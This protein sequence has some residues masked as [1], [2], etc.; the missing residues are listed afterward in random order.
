MKNDIDL[1]DFW[2]ILWNGKF[3][4]ISLTFIFLC[5]GIFTNYYYK[6]IISYK[7]SITIHELPSS[8]LITL[9]KI[10]DAI[11]SIVDHHHLVFDEIDQRFL[12]SNLSNYMD[13][14]ID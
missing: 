6:P 13:N 7:S 1:I 14:I 12:N 5:I 9:V 2:H 8:R 4:I 3:I 11:E 10:D